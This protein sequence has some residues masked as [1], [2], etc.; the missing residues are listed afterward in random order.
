MA[1]EQRGSGRYYYKKLRL[2]RRVFS[3]YFGAGE[4]AVLQ[5]TQDSRAKLER[6]AQREQFNR[7]INEQKIIEKALEQQWKVTKAAIEASLATAGFHYHRGS[8]RR[9]RNCR[10]EGGI[11]AGI[12]SV[13]GALGRDVGTAT[14]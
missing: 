14:N 13:S 1:W 8:W 7:L 12:G 10:H 6:A 9:W 11:K 5:A 3:R 4:A 2:G